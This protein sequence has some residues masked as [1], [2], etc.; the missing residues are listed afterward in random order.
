[1]SSPS[2][3]YA[4]ARRRSRFTHLAEFTMH[5]PFELDDFQQVACEAVEEGKGALVAAPTGAGKTV[6]GEFAVHLALATG[7]KCFYTTPIKALSNQKYHDLAEA[8]GE[9]NVGLLTGDSSVNGH[10]PVVVMTTEVLRNM[11][12]ADSPTL[13]GLGFT[14]MDEVHYLADRM[15]GAVW[16][17]VILHLPQDVQVISL[18]ATVSNAEEFGAW[19]DQVRGTTEVVVSEVR[20]VPLWQHMMVGTEL[21]DLFGEGGAGARAGRS[22]G[23][24]PELMARLRSARAADTG[25]HR[26]DAG[27]P[28]GRRG[29][30]R[31]RGGPSARE[32]RRGHAAGHRFEQPAGEGS[33]RPVGTPS[34][35]Q[36]VSTLDDAGLLPAIV[37][38]FSRNGCDGAVR[39]LLATD[40]RLID[41]AEGE[42]IHHE[43][44]RR[45]LSVAPEDLG[46]LGYHDFVEGLTRGF[47]AHHAGMLPLF[48]EIVEELF[49]AGRIQAVFATETLALGVNMPA[50]TTVIEKM[51]KYNGETHADLT[52]AEY[53][54][55][56]GRAGRRGID[57]EGHAV[58]LAGPR[59][60]PLQVAGL[61][62]TRTY[63]LRSSFRPSANMAVNLVDRMG[64]DE[65]RH[66]LEE[67]F[68]QFQ[69]D[70]AMAGHSHAV[71][72]NEEAMAGYAEA[73]SCHLGDFA[74][75]AELRHQLTQAEKDAAKQRGAAKRAHVQRVL[76]ELSVGDVIRVGSG[77]KAGRA[78]VITGTHGV[79]KR[80][81]DVAV[82]NDSGRL[83]TMT[84]DD[85][86]EP[87]VVQGSI[88]IPPRFNPRKPKDRKDLAATMRAKVPDTDPPARRRGQDT[89]GTDEPGLGG[90][91]GER[92]D[93]LRAALRRHPCHACPDREEHARWAVRLQ[94]LKRETSGLRRKVARRTHTISRTFDR[95]CS[96]LAE[97]G[98]LSEDGQEV[99]DAGRTLQRIYG[100][101][102]L[103]VAECL[104]QGVWR[105]LDASELA[106][107]AGIVIHESR[108]GE[109]DVQPA[110]PTTRVQRAHEL[111]LDLW[112]RI[113]DSEIEHDLP[114]TA[115]PDA[116]IAWMMHRWA[117]GARLEVVLRDSELSAGDF[118]RRAKQVVD[119]LGQIEKA[120]PHPAVQGTARKAMGLMLR[121]VVATDRLD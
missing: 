29:R 37:F 5:H 47:A 45:V 32:Q 76:E 84:A 52:P 46:V 3:R 100:E 110:M 33:R 69:A 16:E 96:M 70:R 20:P 60:D 82:V 78:V 77:W 26:E 50:R 34:R 102:D 98:Y 14:V 61:A 40:T 54:Q 51:V 67:S 85:L 99:T 101:K 13:A 63:P 91:A 81:D 116:G 36:V 108:R 62:S 56:T 107:V 121:G 64:R 65:A 114:V 75:Y 48:R 21:F 90:A 4:A 18:S 79:S 15:R 28:R 86:T 117:A 68:A 2:E 109:V 44:E 35:A 66:L 93:S 41:T 17:E 103:L 38:I 72:R 59:V 9:A 106:A 57:V 87:P 94:Q 8:Y 25:W 23:V 43:V 53:T 118:V 80:H 30:K 88:A 71:E 83:R 39:Q 58:V 31:G 55:L 74:E 95:I 19:L 27:A 115:Q 49:A 22:R 24:N 120:A 10:A 112:S 11:L 7:R 73:M 12:Y 97:W 6:V 42:R 104:R 111:M 92:I 113:E 89:T 105:G 1:M 119:L